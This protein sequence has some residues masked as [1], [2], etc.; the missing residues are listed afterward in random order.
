MLQTIKQTNDW[1]CGEAAL[2]TILQ[3]PIDQA[4]SMLGRDCSTVIE[5]WAQDTANDHGHP[6]IGICAPE[7]VHALLTVDIGASQIMPRQAWRGSWVDRF[8]ED[9]YFPGK[10][11]IEIM[12]WSRK[13]PAILGVPSL[14]YEDR[15]HWIVV[16]QGLIY[17]PSR[18][19]VYE[20]GDRPEIFEAVVVEPR[21][22]SR[23]RLSHPYLP[24]EK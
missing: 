17:D 9:V 6:H 10:S 11:E 24:K 5:G 4:R 14:N 3:I 21:S 19:R 16:H 13:W 22:Y 20:P 8:W 12:V 1:N 23:W 15:E 2:A 7:L 18:K